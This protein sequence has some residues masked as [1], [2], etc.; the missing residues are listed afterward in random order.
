MRYRKFAKLDWEASILGFGCMR[1]PTRDGNPMSPDIDEPEAIRMI[2]TAIDRGVN[3]VDTAYPYHGQRSEIVTGLALRDGYRDRVKLATKLPVWQVNEAAD[4]DK[5][6]NEQLQKLQTDR[7][8]CYLLHALDQSRWEKILHL[9]LLERAEAAIR[10][11]RIGCLGFS[12]H[13][14]YPTFPEIVDGYD[15]WAFCQIQYNYMNLEHQAGLRGLQYAAARGLAVVIME[16]LLGGR[17][18]SPP[19][20]VRQLINGFAEKRSPAD[21]ALQWLWNQPEVTVVLS[22]MSSMDQVEANLGSAES[23]KAGSLGPAELE[24]VERLREKFLERAPIPCTKCGYCLPCPQGVDI[25]GNLEC[26]NDGITFDDLTQARFRYQRFF[27]DAERAG[28]CV[29]C[30]ICESRCPQG[31]SIAD[32]MPRVHSD[33]AN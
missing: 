22:G 28:R 9:N 20:A 21:W 6:L 16:P 17:L 4:F 15:G 7:I 29:Q 13:D 24:L 2:R 19:P 10:D 14:Q 5:L 18:A 30:R 11:G 27:D 32:W 26:Y 8:D 23:G 3:Y 31:I 25:P 1:L 33:L 12:F